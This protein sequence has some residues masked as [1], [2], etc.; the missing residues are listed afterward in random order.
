MK[1]IHS[2]VPIYYDITQTAA[3]TAAEHKADFK[4]TKDPPYIALEGELWGVYYDNL[5]A[6]DHVITA[7][8]CIM[9]SGKPSLYEVC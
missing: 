6:I 4:F 8:P 5:E 9:I 3:M 2:W 7:S 1:N